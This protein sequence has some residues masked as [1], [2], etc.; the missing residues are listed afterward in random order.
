[1]IHF[2]PRNANGKSAPDTAYH[3]LGR[4]PKSDLRG[5]FHLFS[6]SSRVR[7][8]LFSLLYICRHPEHSCKRYP[9][10]IAGGAR[11][12]FWAPKALKDSNARLPRTAQHSTRTLMLQSQEGTKPRKHAKINSSSPAQQ[13]VTDKIVYVGQLVGQATRDNLGFPKCQAESPVFC[14]PYNT[15]SCLHPQPVNQGARLNPDATHFL[16]LFKQNVGTRWFQMGQIWI[17]PNVVTFYWQLTANKSL[18]VPPKPSD[19]S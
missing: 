17:W 11:Q 3:K 4:C 8:C 10:Q 16:Q 15:I 1:M 18:G 2:F 19:V 7:N 6:F 9:R 14:C 5:H 12:H 13:K